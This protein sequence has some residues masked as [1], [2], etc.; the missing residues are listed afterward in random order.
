MVEIE[1]DLTSS[2]SFKSSSSKLKL[3]DEDFEEI[4]DQLNGKISFGALETKEGQP[5]FQVCEVKET[6]IKRRRDVDFL[7]IEDKKFDILI[8]N[9]TEAGWDKDYEQ[10]IIRYKGTTISADAEGNVEVNV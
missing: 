2:N 5:V 3:T 10:F 6:V 8:H 9:F 4:C 1:K 7:S